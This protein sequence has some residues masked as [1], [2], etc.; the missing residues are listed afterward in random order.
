MAD[1]LVSL[2]LCLVLRVMSSEHVVKHICNSCLNGF[3]YVGGHDFSERNAM[4]AFSG[5]EIYS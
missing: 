2:I 1:Y 5:N 4:Y 3:V